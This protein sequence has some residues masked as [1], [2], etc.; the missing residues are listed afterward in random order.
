MVKRVLVGVTALAVLMGG[1][2]LPGSASA[3]TRSSI[4]ISAHV[5]LSGPPSFTQGPTSR[6]TAVPG[7]QVV[8]SGT[9]TRSSGRVVVL[10]RLV[11]GAWREVARRPVTGVS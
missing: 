11:A 9:V 10:Q 3:V 1:L 8:V 4:S 7:E 2:V 6:P 5:Y